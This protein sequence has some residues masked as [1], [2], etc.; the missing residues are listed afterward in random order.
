VSWWGLLTPANVPR[1]I[2]A[3]LH[4]ETAKA[5]NAPEMKNRLAT[6]GVAVMT[7]TPEE[8]AAFIRSEIEKW[9]RMVKASG[10]RLD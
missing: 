4:A 5:M 10:A 3:R 6:Q 7:N 9:G 8:F 2:V 1:E